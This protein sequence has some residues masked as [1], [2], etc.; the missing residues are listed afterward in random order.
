MKFK[1]TGKAVQN[2]YGHNL[3]DGCEVTIT[4]NLLNKFKSNPAMIEVR[5][6]K[7]KKKETAND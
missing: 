4:G 1:Y 5:N 7:K 2:Y 6:T 3:T